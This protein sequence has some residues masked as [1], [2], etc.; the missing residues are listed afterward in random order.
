P[1]GE[2]VIILISSRPEL[3]PETIRSRCSRI[4]FSPLS[5][6]SCRT[7]LEGK[8][9]GNNI[10]LVTRLSMGRPGIALSADL[11]EERTWFLDLFNS[12]M[13]AEKDGWTSREDMELWFDHALTLLRDMTVLTINSDPSSLVNTDLKEYLSKLSKS[14]DAKV[15]INV[16]AELYRVKELLSFNLNKSITWNCTSS[17][18]R[19]ELAAENA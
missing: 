11:L 4:N 8:I 13:K 2:S 18:L 15:I 9:P 1:P 3:L 10:D 14:L 5:P 17:F 12:M 6:E 7:V 16:Y 19:R